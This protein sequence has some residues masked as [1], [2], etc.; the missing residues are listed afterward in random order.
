MRQVIRRHQCRPGKEPKGMAND[1]RLSHWFPSSVSPNLHLPPPRSHG[2]S[3]AVTD[4]ARVFIVDGFLDVL[5][6][7]AV[8]H[9]LDPDR[10]IVL[11]HVYM[12]QLR[13]LAKV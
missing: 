13:F 2:R 3:F 1:T 9:N 4:Q 12:P 11:K 10:F 6:C 8:L 7:C 5:Q